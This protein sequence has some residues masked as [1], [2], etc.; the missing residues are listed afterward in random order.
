MPVPNED[1]PCPRCG[2]VTFLKWTRGDDTWDSYSTRD[3]EC[4]TCGL[5]WDE[6]QGVWLLEDGGDPF[7]GIP[8]SPDDVPATDG[9]EG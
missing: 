6:L 4:D 9:R 2:G 7:R 5:W 3:Y 1:D 8:V